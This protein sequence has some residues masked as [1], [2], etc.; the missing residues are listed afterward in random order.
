M[1]IE[2]GYLSQAK[3]LM[4]NASAVGVLGY[5]AKG[6]INPLI[7]IRT[8]LAALFFTLFM[9]VYSVPVG[10][11]ELHFVGAMVM[12]LTLGFL[13]T[14]F[15]FAIGLALQ[16][17]VF[18][19]GDLAHLS[20]NVL[21]LVLPLIVVHLALGKNIKSRLQMSWKEIVRMDA[22]YYSGVTTMVA[23]WLAIAEV[24]T[25][26]SAWLSFASSYLIIVAM[27]PLVTLGAIAVVN[28]FAHIGWVNRSFVSG[29]H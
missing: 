24:A 29:N 2:P 23:F 12:Y 28:R 9:E 8:I 15:G 16:G 20:V 4:A 10:P 5:Y 21:S 3:I 27:E 1:H 18:N 13:P 17:L 25:P 7:L 22:L 14:L 19:P 11:S 6:L 26:F